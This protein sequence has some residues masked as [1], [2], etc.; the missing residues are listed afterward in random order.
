MCS[1]LLRPKI[2]RSQSGGLRWEDITSYLGAAGATLPATR[3][4]ATG[5]I[6]A[7]AA[8]GGTALYLS[9]DG[10]I[11]WGNMHLGGLSGTTIQSIDIS[12]SY[13][14]NNEQ[15]D[16]LVGTALFGDNLTT[17]KVMLLHLG[18]VVPV[19][20]NLNISIYGFSGGEVS[21]VAFS[22]SYTDDWTIVAIA[23]T[24]SDVVLHANRTYLCIGTNV[25]ALAGSIIWNS[26]P[27]EI[28]TAPYT[29]QSIGDGPTITNINGGLAI[30]SNFAAT[31]TAGKSPLVYAFYTVFATSFPSTDPSNVYQVD[32]WVPTV[33][34]FTGQGSKRYSSIALSGAKLLAGEIGEPP[35]V[36]TVPVR[37]SLNANT[38]TPAF[39]DSG[40]PYGQTNAKVAWSG[41][42]AYCGTSGTESGFSISND[43]GAHWSQV[44]LID[45]TVDVQDV[46]VASSPQSIFLT[47]TS[48]ISHIES[49]WRSAG[50]PL[51]QQWGRVL[52][53]DVLTDKLVTRIS[54]HYRDDYTLYVS[55]VATDLPV[56]TS[57]NANPST[58]FN[59][60]SSTLQWSVTGATS[61]AIHPNIGPDIGSVAT[62][63]NLPI[64]PTAT[65]IYTL[66][67]TNTFT[68]DPVTATVTVTV[69][70]TPPTITE[71]K[72]SQTNI[73]PGASSTLSW[74][75][76]GATAV[77]IN[78]GI[79]AK[80]LSGT[81][82]VSPA[83]TTT[84][85]LVATNGNFSVSATATVTVT[86][87]ITTFTASPRNIVSGG[88][89]TLQWNVTGATSLSI[90]QGIGTV[91]SSGTRTVTP[92]TNTTY[93]LTATMNSIPV[94]VPITITVTAAELP[95]ITTFTAIP[96]HIIGGGLS[97]LSWN[98]SNATSVSIDQGI[99][100][101]SPSGTQTV[102]PATTTT[103][104]L[105]ATNGS[106]SSIAAVTIATD[107][108]P[109]VLPVINTFTANPMTI[110]GSGPSTLSWNVA[111]ATSIVINQGIGDVTATPIS[112]QAVNPAATTTYTLI[113]TNGT[114]SVTASVTI[115]V[116]PVINSFTANP[117]S[118][119]VGRTSTLQW[120][121][122]GATSISISPGLG[123]FLPTSTSQM[124][125]PTMTTMY[126]L[127]ANYGSGSITAFTTVSV[128][129]QFWVSHDRGNAWKQR[130]APPGIIDLAVAEKMVCYVA[131]P[132]GGVAKS[133]TA[134]Q[135]WKNPAYTNLPE[136]TMLSVTDPDTV[137]VG[138]NDGGVTYSSDGGV[139]YT[140]VP[141][142]LINNGPVQVIADSR[143]QQ[144]SFIYAACGN[145][146]YRRALG[147]DDFW[148]VIRTIEPIKQ[149]SGLV[150]V[151]GILYGLWYTKSLLPPFATSPSGAE[152][153]LDAA[154][155]LVFL[156]WDT[157]LVGAEAA[158]F[159]VKPTALRYSVTDTC[160]ILWTVD[161]PNTINSQVM[162][163]FDCLAWHGPDLTLS[164]NAIIGCD[165]ATGRNQEVNF[166]WN[167]ICADNR[168]QLQIA[169]DDQFT[170]MVFD[171]GN[172]YPF[173]LP[174][175]DTSPALVYF[176]SG[177]S[178]SPILNSIRVPEL[179]CG[180][181]YYWRVRARAAVTND[182][183][184]SP[185]SEVR[186]FTFKAGF[187]VTTPYYGPQLL[188]PDNGCGCPCNA[189][190]A[191]SWSPFKETTEYRFELSLNHDM[192]APLVS[193]A[194]K[195]TAYQYGG[196][197]KCNTNYFW[198][199]MAVRPAP[200]EWSAVFSFK[201]RP[202]PEI[203][204]ST[205]APAAVTSTPVLSVLQAPLW[206]WVVIG[207]F[208]ALLVAVLL[209]VLLFKREE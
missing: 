99:G 171:S 193:T 81:Q 155:P 20:K 157:L 127:T 63:G 77:F 139:T 10:G 67:A 29:P 62:S 141:Q 106:G 117:Y 27:I 89:S 108:M 22:P 105:T 38:T 64:T 209:L 182:I 15:R 53:T 26:S 148:D 189:P 206:A 152:R 203:T 98:V 143:Y 202:E 162:V 147:K 153:S 36:I 186:D 86:P 194:V 151:E 129:P 11:T 16:I 158:K 190:S 138:G 69:L 92:T 17:G 21:A 79:G 103:Y 205:V 61:V 132:G 130:Y 160:V 174:I 165:P 122:T 87:V 144:N 9:V 74:N 19:W 208:G 177:G 120:N 68:T 176:A 183:I 45:T 133:D 43:N 78:Q 12:D 96:R 44:G 163:Y 198:R 94:A 197:L 166:T 91:S 65:T 161:S 13:G 173:L 34:P 30:S 104:T 102:T 4:A 97:T 51:G 179:E 80:P 116:I 123:T 107:V 200:S 181:T 6:V 83:A 24:N 23:S 73:L 76:T 142:T 191:F 180:H 207:V 75:V 131:L 71:F 110:L 66:E 128:S 164:N 25:D 60:S 55:E 49:V 119:D 72:A 101:V 18:S 35:S 126:T 58:I 134:G 170:M 54:P 121:V 82:P 5:S 172:N 149:I 50:E 14:D 195:T 46:A 135:F 125:S 48:I 115:T 113:A 90:D 196:Q 52:A 95:T 33:I 178:T 93:T 187:R 169:K 56:I 88:L 199:V 184:R 41:S 154:L 136:I 168:Y 42:N 109:V 37:I 175:V 204:T 124:V 114:Y 59:G 201:V 185:W 47:S 32:V 188:A 145:T 159:N 100:A 85:T 156:E 150:S 192:S 8:D 118:I 84:Y 57:F 3:I 146:I 28:F 140:R 167:D 2:Y 112:S 137:L 111:G 39:S 40:Y 1:I 31:N 7:V 70:D